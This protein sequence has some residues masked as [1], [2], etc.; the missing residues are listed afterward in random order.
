MLVCVFKEFHWLLCEELS[1]G[2]QKWEQGSQWR[3][4]S[5]DV[6]DQSGTVRA[7]TGMIAVELHGQL[8]VVS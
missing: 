4:Q 8:R 1:L 3:V 2:Q 5:S 7:L 6:V